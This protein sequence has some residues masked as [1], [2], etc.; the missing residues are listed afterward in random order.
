[1]KVVMHAYNVFGHAVSIVLALFYVNTN[2]GGSK[3]DNG[4]ID[5]IVIIFFEHFTIVN[6]QANSS[7]LHFNKTI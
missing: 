3:Y 5:L 2:V 7:V 4:A 6:L 1:M